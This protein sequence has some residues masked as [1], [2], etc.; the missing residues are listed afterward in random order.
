MCADDKSHTL[1]DCII[2]LGGG[3]GGNGGVIFGLPTLNGLAFMV[4]LE[5]SEEGC[6]LLF[7]SCARIA[8]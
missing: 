3:G 2:D 1:A 6:L 7:E 8:S 4:S 5:M